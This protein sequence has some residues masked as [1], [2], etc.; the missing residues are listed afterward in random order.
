MARAEHSIVINRPVEQ[1]WAYLHD[2]ENDPEWQSMTQE[3]VK[4]TEGPVGVGTVERITAKLLG[5]RVDTTFEFTEYEPNKRS[6]IKTISGPI[7][8]V[9]TYEVEPT[10]G[11][12][13]FTWS[14]EGEPGGFFR[15]AELLVVRTMSRQVEADLATLKDLLEAQSP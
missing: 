9:G 8:F 13:R 5:R 12:T 7:P 2:P 10:D 4:L 11:G 1:V 3:A 6:Q 14:V 15:L